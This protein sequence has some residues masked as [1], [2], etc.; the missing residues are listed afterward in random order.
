MVPA[1]LFARA[2]WILVLPIVLV[3]IVAVYIFYERH[4]DS[5]VRNMSGSLAGEISLLVHEFEQRPEATRLK[6]TTK[7]ATRLGIRISYDESRAGV[8]VEG[9]G[10]SAYPELFNLLEHKLSHPFMIQLAGQEQEIQISVLMNE[11][12]LEFFAGRK[13]LMSS[14]TYIFILWMAGSSV[15]LSAIAIMFLRNQVRPIRQLAQ[16]AERFGLGLDAP[17]FSPRGAQEVRQ[18]GRAFLEMRERIV[19]QVSTRTEMLAGISHDLRTPITRI[20]LQLALAKIDNKTQQALESDLQDMEHMIQAYLEFAKGEGIEKS[21]IVDMSTLLSEVTNAYQR[22]AAEV[23]TDAIDSA[24]LFV[25]PKNMRR[26]LQNI[27]DNALR[28]GESAHLSAKE[29]ADE[30]TLRIDDKGPGIPDAAQESVFRPFV[31]LDPSRN[32]HTGG[33]GLGLSIARD[34]VLAHGGRI[35][36]INRRQG[37]LRVQI[38]LPKPN[39]GAQYQL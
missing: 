31:R 11:G 36:L 23:T 7:L 15:L 28:Y 21:E 12:R 6:S 5:V 27:V 2:L 38:T 10:Q 8:F 16:A 30:W 18:A 24:L 39:K 26:A 32:Q 14:T 25:R 22:Q 20:R 34:V 17:N 35:E 33:V 37:G 9:Q 1:T 3:Q 29:N 4:W 13:R 19:R